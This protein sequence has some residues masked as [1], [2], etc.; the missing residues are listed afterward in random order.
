KSWSGIVSVVADDRLWNVVALALAL[1]FVSYSVARGAEV[2]LCTR[3]PNGEF[4]ARFLSAGLFSWFSPVIDIGQK[5][6]LDF[7]DLP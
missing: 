6:Q 4:T 3:K 1:S 5:K 2:T 7:D